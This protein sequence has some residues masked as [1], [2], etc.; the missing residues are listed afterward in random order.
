MKKPAS[1][2]LAAAVTGLLMGGTTGCHSQPASQSNEQ[3][4]AGT[5]KH[6]CKGL[7]S[8]TGK[9]GCGVEGKHNCAG[10]NECAGKGGC[11]TVPRHDCAGRND[12]KNQGGCKSKGGCASK[13]E[14][15]GKGGCAVPVRKAG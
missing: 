4:A 1:T 10:K 14:C 2:I 12:C 11:P 5:G 7:N 15:S 6:A 13:N 3:P 8:C 9:G